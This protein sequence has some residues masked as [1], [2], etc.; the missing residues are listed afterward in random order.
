MAVIRV[1]DFETTALAPPEGEV[2]EVGYSDY[3]TE[4]GDVFAPISYLCGAEVIPP[5][6]RAVHHI[7]LSD[8]AGKPKF[9][10]SKLFLDAR[11]AGAVAA[12]NMNF[13]Q[14]WFGEHDAKLIC[15]YK[16]A[17]R[18]WPDAPSHANMAL[19]YWLEDQGKV[20]MNAEWTTP[21]HRA[22]PDAYVTAHI[23]KALF[24]AGATGRDMVAWTKEP[25]LMPRVTFGKH[26][27]A[28][29]PD[30]PAS[31]LA[32]LIGSDMDDDTKWNAAREIKR[33]SA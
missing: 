19:A 1:V 30:V 9:S 6:N 2:I 18:V 31:Y 16:S 14:Q 32:W 24:A 11:D 28:S 17:L 33:R 15:T 20:A 25:K 26:K 3:D 13:E 7:R 10:A 5:E 21:T 23:L 29:W 27:G 8:V 12:H 4:T 22:G